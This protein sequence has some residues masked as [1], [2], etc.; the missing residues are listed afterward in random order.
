MSSIEQIKITNL[1]SRMQ[2]EWPDGT[3]DTWVP[4]HCASWGSLMTRIGGAILVCYS[5]K[6]ADNSTSQYGF[7]EIEALCDLYRVEV[8]YIKGIWSCHNGPTLVSCNE[9]LGDLIADV[10]RDFA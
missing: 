5:T 7:K 10:I 6:P 3:F 1:T 9:N 4:K 8:S 2:I